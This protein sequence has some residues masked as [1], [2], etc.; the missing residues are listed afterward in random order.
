MMVII[1]SASNNNETSRLSSSSHFNTKFCQHGNLGEPVN[2]YDEP[3][4]NAIAG[5]LKLYF[6]ELANPLIPFEYY[7]IFIEAASEL[8]NTL[9]FPFCLSIVHFVLFG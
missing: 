9:C 3:D 5:L 2:L 4:I 6:R 1:M 7:D 8:H